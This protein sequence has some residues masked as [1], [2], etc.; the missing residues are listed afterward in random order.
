MSTRHLKIYQVQIKHRINSMNVWYKSHKEEIYY[1]YL[2]CKNTNEGNQPVF[3]VCDFRDGTM[4]I[5]QT[6]LDINP[7]DCSILSEHDI[8]F[9]HNIYKYK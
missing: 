4:H 8:L 2:W 9:P 7:I 6:C 3:R 5:I 1:C